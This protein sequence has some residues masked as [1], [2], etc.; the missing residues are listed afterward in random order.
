MAVA[1]SVNTTDTFMTTLCSTLYQHLLTTKLLHL[2]STSHVEHEYLGEFYSAFEAKLDTFIE[3]HQGCGAILKLSIPATSCS[4]TG[5]EA[6]T[7]IKTTVISFKTNK[8]FA[9]AY[10]LQAIADELLL[11]TTTAMYKLKRLQHA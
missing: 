2:A 3:C 9:T 8:D 4:C 5:L 11:I 7:A 1:T 10:D 6:L